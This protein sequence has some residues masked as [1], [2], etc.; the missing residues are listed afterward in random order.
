M[1][2]T[3]LSS[4]PS[5][6]SDSSSTGSRY[7]MGRL[8][9]STCLCGKNWGR[10]DWDRH[11]RGDTIQEPHTAFQKAE[12]NKDRMKKGVKLIS[13]NTREQI[14]LYLKLRFKERSDT[15]HSGI[16]IKSYDNLIKKLKYWQT[17]IEKK[18][19]KNTKTDGVHEAMLKEIL[20]K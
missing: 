7:P 2:L 1:E 4:S 8:H 3:S 12:E 18:K 15:P 6:M 17:Y 13:L 20:K 9:C 11:D 19:H 14:N 5:F 16:T 10:Y